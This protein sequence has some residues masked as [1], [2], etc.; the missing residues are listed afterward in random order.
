MA[1][2]LPYQKRFTLKKCPSLWQSRKIDMKAKEL[3][4]P[5][6][7]YQRSQLLLL[8]MIYLNQKTTGESWHDTYLRSDIPA[9]GSQ[10]QLRQISH[11]YSLKTM[12]IRRQKVLGAPA[13]PNGMRVKWNNPRRVQKAE[14]SLARSVKPSCQYPDSRS[15]V[16][17]YLAPLKWSNASWMSGIG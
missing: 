13:S 10:H 9:P 17:K 7:I 11:K 5:T 15:K 12:D 16:A 3:I 8:V 14:R 2:L 4:N 1:Y 6:G